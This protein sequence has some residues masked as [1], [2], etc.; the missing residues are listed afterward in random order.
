MD[1]TTTA[2]IAAAFVAGAG[3]SG[4]VLSPPKTAEGA[5]LE[6]KNT[7]EKIPL[8]EVPELVTAARTMLETKRDGGAVGPLS[9]IAVFAAESCTSG[10]GIEAFD[11]AGHDSDCLL[12]GV[13]EAAAASVTLKAK[14]AYDAGAQ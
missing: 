8:L 2:L 11:A 10:L 4:L 14:K 5:V 6:V 13:A 7:A 12:P 1:K 9:L 3:A